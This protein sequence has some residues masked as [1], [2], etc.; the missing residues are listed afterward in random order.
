ML[1]EFKEF[2]VK[3]NAFDLAVGVITLLPTLDQEISIGLLF[4]GFRVGLGG[5]RVRRGQLRAR[6]AIRGAALAPPVAA[7]SWVGHRIPMPSLLR[8]RGA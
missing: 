4:P 1:K 7:N 3:G 8:T 5:A 2:A 6:S